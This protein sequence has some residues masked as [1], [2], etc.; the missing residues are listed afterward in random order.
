MN[1]RFISDAPNS[2]SQ[3]AWREMDFKGFVPF[4]HDTN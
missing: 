2:G 4:V 3:Q 1:I